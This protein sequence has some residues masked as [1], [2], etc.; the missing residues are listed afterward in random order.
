LSILTVALLMRNSVSLYCLAGYLLPFDF[1]FADASLFDLKSSNAPAFEL[2]VI[3]L[4]LS[5]GSFEF[6]GRRMERG[7]CNEI[8]FQRAGISGD[9]IH[10]SKRLRSCFNDS[11]TIHYFSDSGVS[12]YHLT[13]A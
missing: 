8:L 11:D 4:L 9:L 1:A 13:G 5:A 12:R 10:L 3:F 7:V 6:E 2:F